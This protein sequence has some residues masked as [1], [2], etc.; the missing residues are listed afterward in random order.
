MARARRIARRCF[1]GAIV[2]VAAGYLALQCAPLP[3]PPD[4]PPF[5]E[6]TK[7]LD[8]R[9]RLLY[10]AAGPSD[11]RYT[12]LPLD[13]MPERLRQAVI[14]TE[15]ASFYD[16]PGVSLRGMVRAAV[17]DMRHGEIRS[18]GSTITQQLA[19]NLYFEPEER[20]SSNPLRKLRETALALRLDR[21]RSKDEILELYLNRVYF[22]NLAYGVEAASRTYFG[23][24]ARDLDLAESALI[25]GLLQSPSAYDPFA[26]PEAARARQA[27]VLGRMVDEGYV[28]REEADAARVETLAFNRTPFPIEA[29][30]FVAWVR[31]QLP[32][33]VG[34][35]ALARGDLR[36]TTSLD[37]DLQRTAQQ[38][39][40]RQVARLKEHNVSSG[41]VVAIDPATGHVLAMAGSAD[42]FDES[43]DG[44]YNAALAERQPGSSIKPVIYAA[45][46]EAGYTPSTPVLD[47][48]TALQT[49]RG[50]AYSP[51]NYDYTFHG[52]VPLREAL[53]SSYNVPAARTLAS[54]GI[55][56]AVTLARRVGLTTLRDPARYDLSL[57]LGGGEVRLLDLTAAYATF[58]AEGMSVAPVAVIRVEDAGGRVLYEAPPQPRERVVSEQ[59]AYLISDILSD[60]EAR[61][62]GFG[63]DSVLRLSRPAAVKT[64]TTT[65]FRDNWTAGYTPDLAVGVWV[66]NADNSAMREVSG[67]DGA[68]PVWRD[69]MEAALASRAVRGFA[70]PGGIERVSVCVPSGL[71][72]TAACQRRRLEVFAAGTAPTAEDDYYRP[73]LICDATGDAVASA[74]CRGDSHERVFA[75]PPAEAI[76]WARAAG[77]ALAPVP[78]Y[79]AAYGSTAGDAGGLRIVSPAE[80]VVLRISRD[81]RAEEQLLRIEAQPDAAVRS[82]ELYVDGALVGRAAAPP[83]RATWRIAEGKHEVRARAVGADGRDVWS[84]VTRFSVW[85][86]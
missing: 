22:G 83:Y 2:A 54:I 53:A 43:I 41:A 66:G 71:L 9:G 10:D 82:I 5:S 79:A 21:S 16:N 61:A 39:L 86:P 57:A 63:A 81:L 3:A 80:G 77:V 36:V 8:Q 17:T 65:D 6:S 58:A 20:A 70:A 15:D 35:E 52:M 23:K 34:E 27:T 74:G 29:P 4:P 18:G 12:Q 7:I 45:A 28:S 78:P 51:N 60:N 68:A 47:V 67:V 30:H 37:L 73:L 38:A 1:A 75:F 62:P 42:Y 72:P 59:T 11:A 50:E 76:P 24:R 84:E 46:L 44:A 31:D 69:V 25:A 56:R 40:E 19:R 49:A 64:G 85:P 48:P 32:G 33:L 55:D 14:A 13:Q 26:H